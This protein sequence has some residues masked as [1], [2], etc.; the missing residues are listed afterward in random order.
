MDRSDLA[1]RMKTY[2]SV[3]KSYLTKRV[4]VIIRIDGKSFHNVTKR[5]Y[6]KGYSRVFTEHM[7]NVALA[8]M[9]EMQG[10]KFAYRQSDEISFL[11]T[12]YRTIQ[13]DGWFNYNINKLVSV[14]AACASAELSLILMDRI[15]FDSRAFNIPKDDVC[16]YFIW[17]QVDATRNAIQMA[18]QLHFSKSELHKKSCNQMQEM[19]FSEKGINFNDFTASQKRGECIIDGK[20]DLEIPVFTKERE[21]IERFINIRED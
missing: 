6:P 13:T 15:M 7:L 5:N 9:S 14:S 21:Y 4:P 2:E 18:G 1:E 16:N 3:S 20:L 17:R 11:L 10:C 19:L 12:D 8:V